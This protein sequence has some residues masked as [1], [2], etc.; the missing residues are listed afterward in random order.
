MTMR[1]ACTSS[2]VAWTLAFAVAG[3]FGQD[4][5]THV[6]LLGENFDLS[7]AATPQRLH[8]WPAFDGVHDQY[9]VVWLDSRNPG[10]NDI[11]GQ[12]VSGDGQLLGDNF[13]VIEF[14]DSQS[15]P[16]IAFNAQE[17]EFL[18]SW[19]TQHGG[20]FN[21]GYG[22]RVD[23]AGAPIG[24]Q[25]FI[26]NGGFEAS[27]SYN[28]S[29]NEY[30]YSGRNFAGGG[31][32]GIRGRRIDAEGNLVG[33]DITIAPSGAPDGQAVYNPTA[34][35]YFATWRDQNVRNLQGA[36][37]DPE[38]NRIAG[39]FI[40][41]PRFPASGL[42]AS[43][44]VDPVLNRYFV[45]YGDFTESEVYAQFVDS[46][47]API[48]DEIPVALG[49]PSRVSPFAVFHEGAG[50]F[51]V[52][53]GSASSVAAMVLNADGVPLGDPVDVVVGTAIGDPRM[54]YNGAAGEVLVTW[55]DSRNQGQGEADIFAQLLGVEGVTARIR[56]A[57]CRGADLTVKM[58]GG[59]P[60]DNVSV[61]LSSGETRVSR[62][63]NSGKAKAKFLN[64]P[65]RR[66]TAAAS[67]GC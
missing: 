43:V 25:F 53:W 15:N 27:L 16:C 3:A 10:N 52:A 28:P 66:G 56:K 63:K 44:A 7:S 42:A 65:D 62:V 17:A 11:F 32:A 29:K 41:S 38:G 61:V 51:V 22:R 46:H 45:V 26:S 4:C 49:L 2:V 39:P 19:R 20:A 9:M 18:V 60:R 67:W 37:F 64:V 50:L 12:R 8:P 34:D 40:I 48:G 55:A 30:F 5:A 58:T 21:Q 47:G 35:H 33:P 1:F 6:A 23:A 57:K 24:G 13:P 31:P 14:P 36:I 59:V 54:A